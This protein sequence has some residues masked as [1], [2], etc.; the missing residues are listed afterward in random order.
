M[1]QKY[2]RVNKT[3]FIFNNGVSFETRALY[4]KMWK[5]FG[6]DRPQII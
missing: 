5:K 3:Y 2:R 4:E 6:E 1:L